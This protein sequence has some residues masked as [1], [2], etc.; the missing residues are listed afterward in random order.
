[1]RKTE[2]TFARGSLFSI[3]L[4]CFGVGSAMAANQNQM[5]LPGNLIPKFVD[6]L[7]EA[8]AISVVNATSGPLA[9][10]PSTPSYN[11]TM[12]EFQAQ[13]LPSSGVPG[14]IPANTPSWTWGYLTDTDI[15]AGGVR[16]SYLG[17]VVVAERGVPAHP[18]Y[19]NEL[20]V[21]AVSMGGLSNVQENLPIDMTLDWANPDN[22]DCLPDPVTHDYTN[23]ACGMLPYNGELPDSVHIHGG[24]VAPAFDGGPDAWATQSGVA[25]L[26]YPG[27]TVRVLEWSGRSNNLVPSSWFRHHPTERVCRPGRCLSDRRSG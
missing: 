7:P 12:R 14:S 1:M 8:G 19:K 10:L 2:S 9:G 3:S 25:G 23:P 18:T 21:G 17:P 5:L 27:P 16:P 26:G 15:A 11:L 20:P 24:E 6:P 4:L 13:I 22:I